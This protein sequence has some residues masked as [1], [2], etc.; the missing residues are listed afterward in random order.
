MQKLK[1]IVCDNILK[2]GRNVTFFNHLRI[3][4]QNSLLHSTLTK[5]DTSKVQVE[6]KLDVSS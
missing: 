2:S 6:S 3:L 1:K 4:H 5:F